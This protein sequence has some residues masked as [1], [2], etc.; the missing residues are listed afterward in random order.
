MFRHR[1]GP[2]AL[3]AAATVLPG[4]VLESVG[5]SNVAV[6]GSGHFTLVA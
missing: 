5:T 6:S 3:L 2:L 4:A 1:P